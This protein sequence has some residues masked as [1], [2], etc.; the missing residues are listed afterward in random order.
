MYKSLWARLLACLSVVVVLSL[1]VLPLMANAED[2]LSGEPW[3]K[4]STT[5]SQPIVVSDYAWVS[6]AELEKIIDIVMWAYRGGMFG[7]AYPYAIG[8]GYVDVMEFGQLGNTISVYTVNHAPVRNQYPSFTQSD[9]FDNANTAFDIDTSNAL[10]FQATWMP[11]NT[12]QYTEFVMSATGNFIPSRIATDYQDFASYSPLIAVNKRVK[13]KV[14]GADMNAGEYTSDGQAW[15]YFNESNTSPSNA[16][17]TTPNTSTA[18]EA[19]KQS[20][21]NIRLKIAVNAS[22]F[23]DGYD[24]GYEDGHD[25]GVLSGYQNGYEHGYSEGRD[26]GYDIGHREGYQSGY[27]NG[28]DAGYDPGY[29]QG[30]DDGYTEGKASV[31]PVTLDIPSIFTAMFSGVQSI[32]QGFD[33]NIFGISIAGMLLGILLIVLVAFMVKKLK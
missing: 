11:S 18:P 14:S 13:P 4:S 30:Y 28:H 29:R 12:T 8:L 33:I 3:G 27:D 16:F 5:F 15:G 2:Q 25:E 7:G 31:P 23:D 6:T 17:R 10:L 19:F 32:F 24:D 22:V 9:F 26:Y 1:S 20:L 21:D